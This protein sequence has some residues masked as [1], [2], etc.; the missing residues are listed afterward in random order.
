MESNFSVTFNKIL[1]S[2][3]PSSFYGGG[4]GGGAVVIRHQM[5][6]FS[7]SLAICERNPPSPNKC[8]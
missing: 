1:S 5:E 7:A 2:A 6:T 8:H 3:H 4:G